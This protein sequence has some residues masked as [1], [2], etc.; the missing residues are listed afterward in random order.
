MRQNP[1]IK[2]LHLHLLHWYS[3]NKRS[4][5]WRKTRDPYRILVS[6][7][8][9]QQTQVHRVQQKYPIFLRRFPS[10]QKLARATTAA[11]IRS[12]QGMG[13]NRRALLLRDCAKKIMQQ[14]QGKIPGDVNLLMTLPGIGRYTAH[15]VACFAFKKPVPVV[16]VNAHRVLS[17]VFYRM[18][19][20]SE[21]KD[22]ETIWKLAE[23]AVPK[24]DASRWN[25]ALMD[26][27]AEICTSRKPRCSICPIVS[28]CASV[29]NLSQRNGRTSV[30]NQRH[31][32]RYN[33]L[34]IRIYRGRIVE[35][36]RNLNGKKTI[37]ASTLGKLI[38]PNFSSAELPWLKGI[39]NKLQDD[40]LV[41]VHQRGRKSLGR[42]SPD[43]LSGRRR[44]F[45]RLPQK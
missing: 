1:K 17:R 20:V 27:G 15:A 23:Y 29:Q 10:I 21:R 36:L 6:E 39:L 25:Q 12:W 44:T 31:E 9:L 5:P 2:K 8:M 28:M 41:E 43:V 24:H 26:F 4:L 34:P 19:G 30:R 13:Y 42:H 45:A 16:D 14:H 35:H 37:G 38:K 40:G 7:I 33:G 3:R 22:P 11:V 18:K 32:K